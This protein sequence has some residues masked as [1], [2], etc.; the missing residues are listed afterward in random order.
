MKTSTYT[1]N[2]CEGVLKNQRDR[3]ALD[4]RFKYLKT[5]HS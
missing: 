4:R 1:F 3:Q 2:M 5:K